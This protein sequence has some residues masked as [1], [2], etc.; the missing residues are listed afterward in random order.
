MEHMKLDE[1]K[2][3]IEYRDSLKW[4][5]TQLK[6]ISTSNVKQ[7]DINIYFFDNS[8]GKSITPLYFDRFN[9]EFVKEWLEYNQMFFDK[10]LNEINSELNNYEKLLK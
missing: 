1:I 4:V 6:R 10:K 2:Q 5:Q 3:Q 8:H 7:L 9:K